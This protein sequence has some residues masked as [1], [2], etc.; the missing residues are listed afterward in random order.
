MAGIF[1]VYTDGNVNTDIKLRTLT[2][3]IME[4]VKSEL[5]GSLGEKVKKNIKS[6]MPKSDRNKQHAK[7]ADSILLKMTKGKGTYRNFVISITPKGKFW[8][9]KFPNN[10]TGT[11]R[12]NQPKR[13]FQIGIQHSKSGI[14]AAIARAIAKNTK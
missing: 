4:D 13:F 14:N 2:P 5:M 1:R 10:G 6:G 3:K 8:Y 12:N 9:L 7:T 11:N